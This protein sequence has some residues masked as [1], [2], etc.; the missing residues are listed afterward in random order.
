MSEE[1]WAARVEAEDQEAFGTH[2]PGSDAA[3]AAS[4]LRG[5][6]LGWLLGWTEERQCWTWTT[7]RGG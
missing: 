6:R 2:E 3:A 4:H 1:N 5:V 7:D